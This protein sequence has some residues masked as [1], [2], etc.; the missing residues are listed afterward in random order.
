VG[1]RSFPVFGKGRGSGPVLDFSFS[2]FGSLFLFTPDRSSS[3]LH[4]CLRTRYELHTQ[5][6][7]ELTSPRFTG[8]ICMYSSFSIFFL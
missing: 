7:G 1:A 3:I 4:H 5:S 2:G 6:V 8:F